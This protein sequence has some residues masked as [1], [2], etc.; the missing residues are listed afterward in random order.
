MILKILDA[1]TSPEKLKK[2]D[3]SLIPALCSDIRKFLV[4]SVSETGGHLASNLGAV[5]LTVAIHRVFDT[6]RDRL[7]F[8]V[9]HQ[10]YVHKILTGRRDGF[11]NLRK[12]GGL[13]GFP[14]PYESV[15]DAF[16]AGHA[17]N[18]ISVALGMA[19]AR[20]LKNADY[21]V[22]AFIGDGALT[23]GLAYEGLS[24][25]GDSGEPL[26]IILNDN[27]MSITPNVG[28]VASYL[29][30]KRLKP[31]YKS[32]K[33]RYRR[34]M[35]KIPGGKVI[36]NFT[37]RIKHAV[38]TYLLPC[39]MFEDMGLQYAGPVD[40]HDE[41]RIEEVLRW[42]KDA[43]GPVVVHV[44][45]KKGCGYSFAEGSPD[46]FH[47]IGPFDRR[48]GDADGD[49]MD[50]S[51]VFGDEM[52]RLGEQDNTVCA[53]TA[54]M[55]GGTGLSRFCGE[56]PGRFYDVGIAEGHAASM[57]AGLA[58]GGMKPVFAVYSTFLQR[59]YDMI[60]HDVAIGG[61]HVVLAVDRAGLV[62][63]D[64][65]THQGV[66]DVSAL[67][68]VPG[69]TVFCPAS[70]SELR[71]MTERAVM[72]IGGP[73]A[74]R[75]P[76]GSEGEYTGGG[77]EAVRVLAS[78]SDLTLITYGININDVL[79]AGKMLAEKGVGCDIIKLGI[80]KPLCFDEIEKSALK[81]GRVIVVEEVVSSGCVGELIM[82]HLSEKEIPVRGECLNLGDNFIEHGDVKSL[83]ALYGIDPE[84]ICRA[85]E[86]VMER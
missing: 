76:K 1:V 47:S 69:M 23:G 13:S 65:E 21:S 64:G 9:G 74:V 6:S 72:E 73:A 34:V 26:I 11:A 35:H 44:I 20:T 57:A 7:V 86:R 43:G 28:G 41:A 30:R 18:S 79:A 8:D 56:F 84:G 71:D 27:G 15:H 33:Q 66:F 59:S 81:T 67:L 39:S 37:H 70:Y 52:C 82:A 31:S 16:I 54:A 22:I 60:I 38:K 32:F 19:R 24:D 5:E 58:S 45:T 10:C 55:T 85:A 4:S 50:F 77:S 3:A 75:Y 80:I 78:G 17:S 36:Y 29:S 40:G 2:L 53:I 61:Y 25:A 46:K 12:Y 42:A 68:S 14:K 51:W 62:G 63:G 83:R 48:T 49:S